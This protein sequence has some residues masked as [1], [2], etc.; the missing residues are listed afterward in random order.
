MAG[1]RDI[2]Q[3]NLD[4]ERINGLVISPTK[5]KEMQEIIEEEKKKYKRL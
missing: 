2:I 3:V 5:R 4:R 1:L